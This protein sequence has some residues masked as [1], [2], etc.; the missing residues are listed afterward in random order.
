M[1]VRVDVDGLPPEAE[2]AGLVGD[3]GG[4]EQLVPVRGRDRERPDHDCSSAVGSGLSREGVDEGGG[5]KAKRVLRCKAPQAG[6]VEQ[7]QLGTVKASSASA[8]GSAERAKKRG[9]R[10][11]D[12]EAKASTVMAQPHLE[13]S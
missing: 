3:Y 1:N 11:F 5:G 8:R 2:V 10:E 7:A 6:H 4:L 13:A 9:R 12:S